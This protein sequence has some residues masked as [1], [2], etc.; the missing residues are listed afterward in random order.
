MRYAAYLMLTDDSYRDLEETIEAESPSAA[1]QETFDHLALHPDEQF[2]QLLI[3]PDDQVHVFTRDDK[4]QALTTTEDVPRMI[5]KG[6]KTATI[7]FY[8]N[9]LG[10]QP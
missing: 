8:A 9:E 3:V 4:G 1:A 2:P 6:P 5:A 10:E 7:T